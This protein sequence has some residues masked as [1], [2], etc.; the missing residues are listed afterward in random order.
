MKIRR[1]AVAAFPS[2]AYDTFITIGVKCVGDPP[3]Q[4][5]D[6]L[7]VTPNLPLRDSALVCSQC[8]WAVTPNNPQGNPFHPDTFPGN[9]KVLIG[10]YSTQLGTV[11]Q[12]T[13]M[14][15]Y[16]SNGVSGQ[17]VESFFCSSS[18]TSNEQCTDFNLCTGIETCVDGVCQPGPIQ[19]C[20]G[21]GLHDAC[22]I[23]D[24]TSMDSDGDGVPDECVVCR[25]D[26]DGDGSVGIVDFLI[27]LGG[28]GRC[29]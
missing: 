6:N 27:L 11:I 3:C 16:I 8:G 21:N 10:Q 23:A 4:P 24:G 7:V 2:L 14:L 15:Q 20:N 26:L 5:A 1:L 12:G 28:W 19:D 13:M 18:C 25:S 17:S 29:P 9:G 22:D